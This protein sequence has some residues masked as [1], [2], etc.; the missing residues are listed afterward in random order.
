MGDRLGVPHS[1]L[2]WY[3]GDVRVTVS[4][5]IYALRGCRLQTSW[6]Q[7]SGSA[8]SRMPLGMP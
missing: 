6:R 8:L 7:G 1:R 5:P 3:V 4:P 2:Q